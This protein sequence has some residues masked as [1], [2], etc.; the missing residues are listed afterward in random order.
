MSLIENFLTFFPILI[1]FATHSAP[2]EE[3]NRGRLLLYFPS[4]NNKS[5][6]LIGKKELLLKLL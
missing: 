2:I 3:G 4:T 6:G 5:A 1:T